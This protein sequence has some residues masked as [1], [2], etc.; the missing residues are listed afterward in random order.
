MRPSFKE[1]ELRVMKTPQRWL[2]LLVVVLLMVLEVAPVAG[3]EILTNDSVITMKKAGLSD[4]VI[5]ARI[6]SSQTKFD[7]STPA[8]ISLKQAGVSDQV[9]EAIVTRSGPPALPAPG[10][11]SPADRGALGPG[12]RRDSVFHLS[13]EKYIELTPAFSSVETNFAF[14][15]TKSELVL[16]GRKAQYRISE[17]TPVF[18]SAFA[19]NEMPLVRLK[20][21]DEHD[22]RNLKV[23]SGSFMPFGGTHTVGVRSEDTVDVGWEK[24]SRGFYRITPRQPL[25]PGEYGF[26]LT[27][28]LSARAAGKV[29]DFGV[30]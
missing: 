17:R 6:R 7:V 4:A 15:T 27:Q 19:P 12:E 20:P 21:G 10:P 1:K 5:L 16:K 23:S 8:L 25:P 11:V 18:V 26:I 14:F 2:A 3:Q 13:G 28:G 9:I 29:Y 30:D 22:D 24:D